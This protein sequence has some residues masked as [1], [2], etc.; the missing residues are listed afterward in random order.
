MSSYLPDEL[1]S[2]LRAILDA[3][4]APISADEAIRIA[5][6]M[7]GDEHLEEGGHDAESGREGAL[8]DC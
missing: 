4:P 6:Q 5:V 7:D 2:C 3:G 8:G 1:K